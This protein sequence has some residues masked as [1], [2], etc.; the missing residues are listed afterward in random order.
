MAKNKVSVEISVEEKA[1]LK[2]LNKL[3]KTMK[4]VGDTGAKNIGKMDVAMGAFVGTMATAAASKALFAIK[5]G[6][7]SSVK[8]AASFEKSIIEINTIIGENEKL[9]KEQILG[10]RDLAKQYGTSAQAQ[11]KSFYQIISA[12]TTDAVEASKLLESANKLAIGGIADVG[13]SID[14]LTSVLNS[15]GK[16]NVSAE[17]A[18]DS[19]FTTVKLGKTTIEELS[20]SLGLAIPSAKAAGVGLDLV[21]ASVAV[22]TKNAFSTSAAVTRV[23]GLLTALARNGEKLGPT[24][25]IAAVKTDGL[26]TVLQRLEKRTGGNASQ[27]LA[28]LGRQE[29]VQA[30][31]VLM[32]DGAADLVDVYGKFDNKAGAAT[33]A[34]NLMAES[35]SFKFDQLISEIDDLK[36]T[37]GNEL[38]PILLEVG[39]SIKFAFG[40]GETDLNKLDEQIAALVTT[41][42]KM[43]VNLKEMEADK[44][45]FFSLFGADIQGNIDKT[46]AKLAAQE[47]TLAA[48]FEERKKLVDQQ[49]GTTET[50]KAPDDTGGG[51]DGGLG[52]EKEVS[53]SIIAERKKLHLELLL[54]EQEQQLKQAEAKLAQGDISAEE[55]KVAIDSLVFHENEKAIL[56]QSIAVEKNKKIVDIEAQSLANQKAMTKLS[57]DNAKTEAKQKKLIADQELKDKN[58]FFS[59][60]VSLSSSKNKEL[61]AIGKAA[62][63][64][65]IAQATPPAIASSFNF[66]TKLGGPVLGGIFAGIAGAA[67]AAQ[68]AKMAGFADGGVVGGFSGA[69]AGNDN[70]QIK[71]RNGEMYLN[72]SQQRQLFDFANG[73]PVSENGGSGGNLQLTTVVQIDEREIARSVRNQKL[74]GFAS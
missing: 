65:Q 70:T 24:M 32:R 44:G 58:A 67:Q 27:L 16:G 33:G 48:L 30:S 43:T 35:A 6:F 74:E 5:S 26:V 28:L 54:I 10:L 21:N 25:N 15:Y 55:R 1:A 51:G 22:L 4:N 17:E 59:A 73:T 42:S 19:L 49:F 57:I 56:T 50:P 64:L 29:A 12:G 63:I 36:I 37:L 41:T 66:G 62:G 9:T 60:A 34:F 46:S 45:G 68:M 3:S 20:S 52:K 53:A 72:A 40:V 18:A 8:A 47:K 71:A 39:E 2:A 23:N 69:T 11:A 38:L 13:G 7:T 14:I 61:A 31:Q